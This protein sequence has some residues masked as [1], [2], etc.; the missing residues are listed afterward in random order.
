MPIS[1][2]EENFEKTGGM[3]YFGDQYNDHDQQYRGSSKY[4]T[5][6][7]PSINNHY[8]SMQEIIPNN[9]NASAHRIK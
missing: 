7:L 3:S 1:E 4:G 9:R 6:I 2:V 5:P 8:S